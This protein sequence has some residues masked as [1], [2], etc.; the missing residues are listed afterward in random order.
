MAPGE[1]EFD[2]PAVE[3]ELLHLQNLMRQWQQEQP[4]LSPVIKE[5]E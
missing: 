3:E 2:T 5:V 1:N 4:P